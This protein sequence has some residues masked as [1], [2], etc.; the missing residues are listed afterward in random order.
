MGQPRTLIP[1]SLS[2]NQVE[3]DG[4]ADGQVKASILLLI[5]QCCRWRKIAFSG[6]TDAGILSGRLVWDDWRVLLVV[7]QQ[8]DANTLV[9]D[10]LQRLVCT[11]KLQECL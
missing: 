8:D 1:S 3:C 10:T 7:I 5:T 6:I 11:K 4:V 2:G 9:E